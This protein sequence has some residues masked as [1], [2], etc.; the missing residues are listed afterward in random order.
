MEKTWKIRAYRDGDEEGILELWKSVYPEM[1]LERNKWLSWWNW[2]YNENPAGKGWIWLADD[3]N[4]IVGQ[5]ALIPVLMKVGT[6]LVAGFQSLDT[7]THPEYRHQGIFYTLARKTYE[8]VAKDNV[9]IGYGFS[10]D[11]SFPAFIKKLNWLEMPNMKVMVKAFDWRNAIKL[12]TKN[13]FL[14]VV[15]GIGAD[16]I[17]NKTLSLMQRGP[18]QPDLSVSQVTYFD[19][20]FD[21]LWNNICR[22]APIMRVRNKDYLNWRYHAPDKNFIIFAAEKDLKIYGY[23]VM[24]NTIRQNAKTSIIF[25]LVAQSEEVMHCLVSRALE[26]CQQKNMDVIIY[27]SLTN[28]TYRKILIK[29]GFISLPFIKGGHFIIYSDS[30][31]ISKDFL[32]NSKNWFISTGDSDIN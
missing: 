14:Q 1:H 4:K 21:E 3:G 10:N 26:E 20:R 19:E 32:S 28:K 22:Q 5:Y 6:E 17:F 16:L 8:E 9:H 27:S 2:Q 23:L 7:M 12:R 15:L 11:N 30:S 24:Q 25:D 18:T 13:K 29:N 31:S